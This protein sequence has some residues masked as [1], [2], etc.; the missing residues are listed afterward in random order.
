MV[1]NCLGDSLTYGLDPSNYS[2]QIGNPWVNQLK[3]LCG[4]SKVNN[5][6]ISAS[7]ISTKTSDRSWDSVRNPMVT[8]YAS[9]ENNADVIIVMGGTND[10]T[11]SIPIGTYGSKNSDN[12]YGAVDKLCYNLKTKYPTKT[13]M[14]MLPM[15]YSTSSANSKT[16]ELVIPLE[17]YREVIRRVCQFYSI[18]VFEL[19]KELGF[20]V[21]FDPQKSLFIPDGVHPNQAGHDVM[22]RKISKYINYTL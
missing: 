14:F 17:Q 11:Q 13:I 16:N 4:F 19:Y 21:N 20:T 10:H 5:Y 3:E 15:E 12:F 6:G 9:M 7:T 2:R 1:C 8:R 18:P 22:A